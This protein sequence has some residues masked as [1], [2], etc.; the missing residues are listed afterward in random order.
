MEISPLSRPS[1]KDTDARRQT[2]AEYADSLGGAP[3]TASVLRGLASLSKTQERAL[4]AGLILIGWALVVLARLFTLQVLEHDSLTRQARRQ[5]E[6]LESIDAPRGTI[7]DRNGAILAISS[8]SHM[9]VVNPKRIPKQ[10]AELA[11][12]MLAGVLGQDAA[13]L[14]ASL[15]KAAASRNRGGYLVVND[16]LSDEQATSLEGLHLDWLEI[17]QSS[18]RT[19]PNKDVAAHVIGNVDWK[20]NGV[21]GIERK[22]NKDL[23]GVAGER[24]AERDGKEVAY[25]SEIVKPPVMGRSVGLTIDRQLQFIAKEAI[26][27]AVKENGA[28]Y[29]SVVAMNPR[30]GEVLA[31]ENYPTYDPNV[32]LMAGQKDLN[33]K[34]LAVGTPFEPGSVFKVVTLSAALETT[35][36][37]PDSLIDCENG[38]MRMF[39]R[40]IHDSHRSGVLSM[41]DVLA[42]SSNIGAIKIG[43]QVGT[44]NL[45]N[46]I[47]RFGFGQ[48]TGIELPGEAPGI[49]R[50][51]KRWQPT[52][53]GSI[54]MGHEIG[55]TS[56]QLAQMGSAIANGGFL[57]TPHLVAW[58]QEPDGPRVAQKHAAPVQILQP[59]TVMAMRQ[60]MRRVVTDEHGTGHHL[61][62]IGYSLAG[63]TGTA[64]IYD[65]DHHVYTHRYNASFLG[66]A[67]ANNP[68]IV[69]VVTVSGTSGAA[70]YGG[71]AAGPAFVRLMQ[72]SLTRLGVVR[73]VPEEIEQLIAKN[74]LK[75]KVSAGKEDADA[76]TVAELTTPF[77][78]EEMKAAIDQDDVVAVTEGIAPKA[79][80][81]V[82]KTVRDVMQ[83]A[84][85]TGIEVDML[86]DGLA[87]AQNPPAGT[88]LNPGEHIRV[89]FQR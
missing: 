66:F 32:R 41:A 87:R 8:N 25:A 16:H 72:A 73:D 89:R 37:R 52:T 27:Q 50:S 61:H 81:F 76:D 6:H 71:S 21:A 64:Q 88:L 43:M 1:A 48:R 63:K 84:T 3:D 74:A 53:I 35:T 45:Y 2:T 18:I 38:V 10:K 31:L 15:E 28:D 9:A 86:G 55:V 82:G 75:T 26:Q 5:Q 44:E 62:V 7:Y 56:L 77:S 13:Q 47:R 33:R 49:L 17:R 14:Q 58:E 57:V 34:N 11:A 46:Y 60:M 68:A 69:I 39:K 24:R 54:P 85:A 30:T 4:F 23:A 40:V 78:A 20:G 29:A 65:Y 51:L 83:E 22:L 70:G 42:R 12:A 80:N 19:Y 79:P 59:E 67:P 36:L